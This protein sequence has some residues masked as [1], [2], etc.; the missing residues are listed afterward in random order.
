VERSNSPL[1]VSAIRISNVLGIRSAEIRPG[2]V[3]LVQGANG[4]GKTS[5][6]EAVRAVLR[7]GHDATLLRQG[8]DYGEIVMVLD[9][10]QEITKEITPDRTNVKLTTPEFGEIKRARSVI[11]ELCDAFAL[12]P[13]EFLMAK[14]AARL[15]LLLAA[16]P[17]KLNSRDLAA[18]APLLTIRPDYN[19][20]AL[21]VL[22][23]I[24][25]DLYDQRT[26]VNR[27][28]REKSTTAAELK[29]ALPDESL[30]MGSELRD[31]KAEQSAFL[32]E[33]NARSI[34][35]NK[36]AD[37]FKQEARD[38]CA[39]A[40]DVAKHK[41]EAE[42]ERL[43]REYQELHDTEHAACS[44]ILADIDS[45]RDLAHLALTE[46]SAARG[47][48]LSKKVADAEANRDAYVRALAARQH[49]EA[50]LS[51]AEE[52]EDKSKQYTD[53][54]D[55]L[56]SLREALLT[57]LPIKGLSISNGDIL[58]DDI[59]FDR[60]NEARRVR[61]AVDVAM[62]RAGDLPLLIVD[63]CER[64]DSASLEA[65]E[66][67]AQQSGIQLILARVTDGPLEIKTAIA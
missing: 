16:I 3:T 40:V 29:K 42:I 26:G 53:A 32:A 34:E 36:S 61:L 21:P 27:V 13:V 45:R 25:K 33:V 14:K 37:R 65:L 8:S 48:E 30:S 50:L 64:L 38:F 43:R 10:G 1:R 2:S 58:V 28:A 22:A 62:L 63:G 52:F 15:E 56:K 60:L 17:L 11:D 24:E 19:S 7:G 67:H 44:K 4:C 5:T 57:D 39:N 9:D 18:I 12:N 54:L 20:H 49:I 55:E 47:A 6:L 51:S 46:E 59:P 66:Q 41:L 35:F 31:A 23:L